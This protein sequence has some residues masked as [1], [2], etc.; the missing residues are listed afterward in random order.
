M[1]SILSGAGSSVAK[2][3]KDL[4]N[5]WFDKKG[6][7]KQY[8]KT[9]E[10]EEINLSNMSSILGGAGTK[11]PK[12]FRDLYDLWF[13]EQGNKKQYLKTLEKEGIR[14]YST[15]IQYFCMDAPELLPELPLGKLV[16]LEIK[17][18]F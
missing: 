13:D 9:L 4:Y 11:A 5:L 14:V 3:F 6:N 18:T 2:A 7:R 10:K 16:F 17:P 12:T 8:L 15:C 1:S